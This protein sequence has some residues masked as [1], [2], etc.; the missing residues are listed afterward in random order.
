MVRDTKKN[1]AKESEEEGNYMPFP[2]VSSCPGVSMDTS[3]DSSW[4]STTINPTQDSEMK[5][6]EPGVGLKRNE[7]QDHFHLELPYVIPY[8][9]PQKS[10]NKFFNPR[11]EEKMKCQW[12][13]RSQYHKDPISGPIRLKIDYLVQIPTST[14]KKKKIEILGKE[15]LKKLDLDNLTKFLGDVLKGIVFDDDSQIWHLELKKTWAEF[16]K[17]CIT[18][19]PTSQID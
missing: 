4:Q 10:G 12:I 13:I 14:S 15:C 19:W 17:T 3:I 16:N 8:R 5:C 1:S 6:G 2:T 11:S 18:I 7:L 9:A